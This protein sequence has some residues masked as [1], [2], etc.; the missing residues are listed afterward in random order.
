MTWLVTG[1]AGYIGSHVVR[2]LAEAGLQPVVVDDLSSGRLDFVP[3]VSG[4]S[5]DRY[6]VSQILYRYQ[7]APP[8]SDWRNADNREREIP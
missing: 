3:P 1:G 7:T 8:Q 6:T 5:R 2:A 4:L